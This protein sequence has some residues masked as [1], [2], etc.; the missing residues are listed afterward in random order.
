MHVTEGRGLIKRKYTSRSAAVEEDSDT[1]I[2]LIRMLYMINALWWQTEDIL[3][4]KPHLTQQN[5]SSLMA[6]PSSSQSFT[7]NKGQTLFLF[8]IMIHYNPIRA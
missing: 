7:I 8:S 2:I 6:W 4:H 5:S 3:K 1:F